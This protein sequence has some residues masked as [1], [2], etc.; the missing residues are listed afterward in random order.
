MQHI[1]QFITISLKNMITI[2]ISNIKANICKACILA[3]NI[4]L[5][6]FAGLK[7]GK[8][9]PDKN[10]IQLFG[11]LKRNGGKSEH[12]G[13]T[14]FTV[15]PEQIWIKVKKSWL[16]LPQ[17]LSTY[18]RGTESA[19]IEIPPFRPHVIFKNCFLLNRSCFTM[20]TFRGT[21]TM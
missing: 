19:S 3:R 13:Y 21:F 4:S 1:L 2:S 8:E 18:P 12:P 10:I 17:H 15:W 9:R 6:N 5:M 7:L 14:Q 16:L 11:N 20:F